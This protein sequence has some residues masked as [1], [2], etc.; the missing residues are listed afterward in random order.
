[1]IMRLWNEEKPQPFK[2]IVA[3]DNKGRWGGRRLVYDGKNVVSDLAHSICFDRENIVD[4]AYADELYANERKSDVK[5]G[6]RIRIVRMHY[7]PSLKGDK[8]SCLAYR[9]KE[10]VVELIDGIGQLHGTWGSLAVIPEEDD[11]VILLK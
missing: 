2:L 7:N 6:D 4:W 5:V 10:G 3:R 11:F 1:M 9:G 8:E